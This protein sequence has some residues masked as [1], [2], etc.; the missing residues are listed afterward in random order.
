MLSEC[1]GWEVL[2]FLPPL[3]PVYFYFLDKFLQPSVSRV[4]PYFTYQCGHSSWCNEIINML[5][6]GILNFRILKLNRKIL[7]PSKSAVL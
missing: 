4:A 7:E 5:S 1:A 6:N 3:T 2:R